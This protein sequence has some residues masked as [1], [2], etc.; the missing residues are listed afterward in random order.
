M[1]IYNV[2][3]KVSWA[4]HAEWLSW[5]HDVLIPEVLQTDCFF[6]SRILRLLDTDEDDG[7]TYAIQFNAYTLREYRIFME[8]YSTSF[9]KKTHEKWNDLLVAFS[10]TMEVLH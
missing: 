2:T 1:I 5:I 4:I 6:E 3:T 9:Q 8:Q 10:S 7:P